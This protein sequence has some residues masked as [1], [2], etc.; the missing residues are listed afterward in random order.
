MITAAE[1]DMLN[2]PIMNHYDLFSRTVL[3]SIIKKLKQADMTS[4]AAWQ[5]QR[6]IESGTVYDMALRIVAARTGQSESGLRKLFEKAG[7]KALG[8]DNAIYR[9]AGLNPGRLALSPAMLDVLKAGIIKTGNK[10]R[11]LTMTTAPAAQKLFI[12]ALDLAYTQ[13]STGAFSYDEAIKNAAKSVVK[14]GLTVIDY[15]TG[16]TDQV[17]VAVRRAVLTGVS[18]TTARMSL[19]RA[20]EM[21]QDLV[22]VSAHYGARNRGD[23]PE[24]HEMWQGRV[25]SISGT[26]PK[27]KDFREQTGYGTGEGLSGWNCRH[28]FYPFFDGISVNP[29]TEEELDRM[30]KKVVTYKGKEISQYEASQIQRSIERNI[31]KYKREAE[32]LGS[33]GI[34]NTEELEKVKKWQKKMRGFVAETEMV[35]QPAREGGKVAR[36][37][38]PPEV[39]LESLEEKIRYEKK[40]EIAGVFDSQTGKNLL[41]KKGKAES[42]EFT[43]EE[44]RL[45]KNNILTHNHPLDYSFSQSDLRTIVYSGAKE[46]RAVTSQ[47]TYSLV[48][49]TKAEHLFAPGEKYSFFEWT[50]RFRQKYLSSLKEAMFICSVKYAD[51]GNDPEYTHKMIRE[52]ARLM[53][54]S[55]ER[56]AYKRKKK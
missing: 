12:D 9:K 38:V 22:Q 24:N 27:Y 52:F 5:M 21:G 37:V 35:R 7:V 6:L 15:E 29:Y 13:V 17:D 41:V 42:V 32:L 55:Y 39:T 51:L 10:L 8:F 31:R 28:S 26:H 3:D 11:N 23:I 36:M 4:S 40:Y 49:L 46:I 33:N 14:K 44:A 18:Q 34:D 48:N 19:D 53:E 54:W 20:H 43:S 45:M 30:A 2:T 50:S 16:K 56:Q 25:Y 1:F 47:H